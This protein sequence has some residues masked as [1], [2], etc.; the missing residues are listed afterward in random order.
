HQAE[1][2]L[3]AGNHKQAIELYKTLLKLADRDEWRE[4]LAASYLVR[5]QTLAEKTL[6]KEAVVFYEN[7]LKWTTTAPELQDRYC[8]WLLA[9]GQQAKALDTVKALTAEQLDKALPELAVWLGFFLV[10]GQ[11]EWI[12]SL[13]DDSALKSH[14]QQVSEALQAHRQGDQAGFRAK[15]KSLPYR[16]AF[17]DLKT[18]LLAVDSPPDQALTLLAKIP[19]HS[20]YHSLTP[21]LVML[22]SQGLA[23]VKASAQVSEAQRCVISQAKGLN[24]M[25][26]KL[27]NRLSQ[28]HAQLD[29]AKVRF[30]LLIEHRE[31]FA[32]DRVREGCQSLLPDYPAGLQLFLKTFAHNDH[33]EQLRL[34]ALLAEHND[35]FFEAHRDWRILVDHWLNNSHQNPDQTKQAAL[36]LRHVAEAFDDEIMGIELLIESLEVDPDDAPSYHKILEFWAKLP[37][38]KNYHLWLKKA[39][40][41]FP[42][43]TDFLIRAVKSAQRRKAFKLATRYAKQLLTLDPINTLARENLFNSHLAHALKLLNGNKYHLVETELNAAAAIPVAKTLRPQVELLHAALWYFTDSNAQGIE[44]FVQTLQTL[45]PD[46]TSAQWQA[47]IESTRLDLPMAPISRLLPDCKKHELSEAS[48][49][50]LTALI[51]R[52]RQQLP[53]S[54]LIDKAL[55]TIKPSLKHSMKGLHY[56][57][58]TLLDWCELLERLERY[59]LIKPCASATRGIWDSPIWAYYRILPELQGKPKSLGFT[60]IWRLQTALD[61]ARQTGDS[62][63]EAKLT[64]LLETQRPP[65]PL[66][67]TPMDDPFEPEE[68][69]E[70]ELNPDIVTDLFGHLSK[71]ELTWL[72]Q[73]YQSFTEGRRLINLLEYCLSQLD[74]KQLTPPKPKLLTDNIDCVLSLV[75]WIR[76]KQLNI[77]VGIDQN[78]IFNYFQN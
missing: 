55:D 3:A 29:N 2:A 43:R 13:P 44:Q 48:L 17:R 61:E 26:L 56:R 74:Q 6:L 50:H 27:L 77:K 76:A 66:P 52:Y 59:D 42:E 1:Q 67:L 62:R 32:D 34:K 64:R 9:C 14:W 45:N 7:Y 15:L 33:A 46:P 21:A 65:E 8:L 28:Q 51:E 58:Q 68:L 10:S 19:E 35:A 16:S 78:Q 49:Q 4:A 72:L 36:V 5:A 12:D 24:K 37:D 53:D 25:Q 30:N 18:L 22:F 38:W 54:T 69:D 31:L 57:E 20:P 23:L 70:T 71:A 39:L 41:Q 11:A 73:D 60:L 47:V 40:A 75:L 63:A